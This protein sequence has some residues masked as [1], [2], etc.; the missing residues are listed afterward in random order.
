MNKLLQ[1]RRGAE[2]LI[3]IDSDIGVIHRSTMIDNGM[4]TMVPNGEPVYHHKIICRVT[5]QSGH[6]WSTK[7]WD[8]GLTIDTTPL[9]LAA[10]DVD[11]LQGDLLTWRGRRYSVGV[12]TIPDNA[13]T[14]APLTA[15]K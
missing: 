4:G 3:N 7:P 13:F 8:G 10:H 2:T 12:V 1:L 6:V 11:L 15:V 5:Y 9:V 14:Q